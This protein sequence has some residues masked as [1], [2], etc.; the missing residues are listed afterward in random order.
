MEMPGARRPARR[1]SCRRAVRTTAIAWLIAATGAPPATAQG[2]WVLVRPPL[3]YQ[4]LEALN[5]TPGFLAKSLDDQVSEVLSVAIDRSAPLAGWQRWVEYPSEAECEA[6]RRNSEANARRGLAELARHPT[7][8]PEVERAK[9]S[10]RF[11]G[12][13]DG[14]RFREARCVPAVQA[15]R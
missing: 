13:V 5:T 1:N 15:P 4:R 11:E 2:G 10:V 14:L 12:E 6:G 7:G 8:G 3:D 9:R